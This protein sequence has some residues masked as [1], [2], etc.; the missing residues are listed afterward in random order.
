MP[1][2]HCINIT[3]SLS[4]YPL[5]YPKLELMLGYFHHWNF[6]MTVIPISLTGDRNFRAVYTKIFYKSGLLLSSSP[7]HRSFQLAAAALGYNWIL[8]LVLHPRI[9]H[10][11]EKRQLV[12]YTD[13]IIILYFSMPTCLKI[14]CISFIFNLELTCCL[15]NFSQL[16][17]YL[18]WILL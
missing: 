17:N 7:H 16:I 5:L 6:E 12:I 1:L 9:L 18:L 8:E 4:L 3:P 11:F 15:Y 2:V 13:F 14:I 10:S